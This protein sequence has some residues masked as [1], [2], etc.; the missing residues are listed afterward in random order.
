M[1][2]TDLNASFFTLEPHPDGGS[3]IVRLP[4]AFGALG[5]EFE[6]PCGN[7]SFI[8]IYFSN[9]LDTKAKP[10]HEKGWARVGETLDT[11]TLMPSIS[12]NPQSVPPGSHFFIENGGVRMV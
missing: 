7:G 10:I 11:L 2:L 1:R 6:D 4:T 9:P 5:V 12:I 3:L 8:H